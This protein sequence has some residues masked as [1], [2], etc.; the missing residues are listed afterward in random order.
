MD[1]FLLTFHSERNPLVVSLREAGME[2]V[3]IDDFRIARNRLDG[4]VAYYGNVFTE[5]KHP[6]AFISL[7]KALHRRA[8]PYVFWNRDAPW[9]VGIKKH[10]EWLLHLLKPVDIYLTHSLQMAHLF[11]RNPAIY[12]PN[13]AQRAYCAEGDLAD[14]RIPSHY[15]YDVTFI[16]AVGNLKRHN[17][18]ERAAFL[19]AVQAG[20]QARSSN[21][22][23]RIVDTVH[24]NL[25]VEEQLA[26]IRTSKVN[27]NFG[28]MCDLPGNPSWGLPE[29]VFGIPATGGFLLTDW[30]Q[31]IPTTFPDDSCDFF[32]DAEECVGKI[33]YYLP[34]FDLL[35]ARAEKLHT[36]VL[37]GHTYAIR[38]RQLVELL[39]RNSYAHRPAA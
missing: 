23:F 15:R 8:I 33:L 34:R 37:A 25:S 4:C 38:A 14:L 28:A 24:E 29:R 10:R 1:G 11:S 13:A 35:R 18:R 5:I 27:L 22:R 36:Q 20:L 2:V 21:A 9:N 7:L 12:F 31:A 3:C 16:G 39:H 26:L 32:H 17:C 19:R 30:R 6:L